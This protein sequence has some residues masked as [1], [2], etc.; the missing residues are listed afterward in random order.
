MPISVTI[1]MYGADWCGDSQRAKTFLAEEGV[2]YT[3]VDLVET[4]EAKDIVIERNN[5]GASIP[6]VVFG[7]NTHLVEPSNDDLAEKLAVLSGSI[8]RVV[9]DVEAG[10]FELWRAGAVVSSASY[11]S[12]PDGVVVVPHVETKPEHR[13]SGNAALLMDG[14]LG[15]LRT[16]GRRIVP[17]CSF[18]ADH[19]RSNERH[20]DLLAG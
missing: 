2:L 17:I 7:D 15:L 4:P 19:V 11:S 3:F 1:T 16:S 6:V 12:Q 20:V 18:A 14:M 9:E 10:R 5:G 8:A 13:G